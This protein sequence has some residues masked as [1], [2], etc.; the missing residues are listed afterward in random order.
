MK[1]FLEFFRILSLKDFVLLANFLS[2]DVRNAFH[3]S[4]VPFRENFLFRE[5]N[6]LMDNLANSALDIRILVRTSQHGCPNYSLAVRR[7]TLSFFE[8]TVFPYIPGS[9]CKRSSDGVWKTSLVLSKIHL[10]CPE[11]KFKK[12]VGKKSL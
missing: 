11:D 12:F 10:S 9:G 2:R 6:I 5:I 8:L 3:V 4:R 7:H 1:T